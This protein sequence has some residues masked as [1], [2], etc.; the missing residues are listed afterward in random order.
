VRLPHE[1]T[2]SRRVS[3]VSQVPAT[4]RAVADLAA[5]LVVQ[6]VENVTLESTSDYW[7]IWLYPISGGQDRDRGRVRPSA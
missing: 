2:P 5:Q 6:G 1:T 3:R 7:R 4:T